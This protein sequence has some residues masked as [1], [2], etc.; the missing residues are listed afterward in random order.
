MLDTECGR[1]DGTGSIEAG[2]WPCE[3]CGGTGIVCIPPKFCM[4]RDDEDEHCD[5]PNCYCG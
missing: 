3:E 4:V 2:M 5:Y 1:C